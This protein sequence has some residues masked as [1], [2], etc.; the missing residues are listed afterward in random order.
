MKK[1]IIGLLVI[2][3][4]FVI[5]CTQTKTI[6]EN[7]SCAVD[8]DC[9][10]AGCCHV[11]DSVNLKYAPKCEG[12]LCTMECVPNTLDCGQGEIKCVEGECKAM[13]T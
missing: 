10:P 7:K 6:P 2:S 5:A 3:L 12:M 9:V 11:N 13:I 8:T 4:V 1:Y